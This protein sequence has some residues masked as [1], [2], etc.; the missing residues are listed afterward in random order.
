MTKHSFQS[1]VS[2]RQASGRL[3]VG[4]ST[5]TSLLKSPSLRKRVHSRDD[6]PPD[7]KSASKR[8]RYHRE[9]PLS[10]QGQM[11]TA[12]HDNMLDISPS[13][14]A[15]PPLPDAPDGKPLDIIRALMHTLLTET[16]EGPIFHWHTMGDRDLRPWTILTNP[17]GLRCPDVAAVLREVAEKTTLDVDGLEE[18]L[19]DAGITTSDQIVL[20]SDEP[21]KTFGGMG[22]ALAHII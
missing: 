5:L 18:A 11:S 3:G 9:P 21:L 14:I 7:P 2:G 12:I 4:V 15:P 20:S 10:T 6:A 13:L 19:R 17:W 1:T 16:K 8:R 22:V